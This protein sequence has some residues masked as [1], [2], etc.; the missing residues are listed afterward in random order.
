MVLALLTVIRAVQQLFL[1]VIYAILLFRYSVSKKFFLHFNF[2][3]FH[4]FF[5]LHLASHNNQTKS[6]VAFKI[7]QICCNEGTI[8]KRELKDQKM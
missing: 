4:F 8:K 6:A 5:A 3:V 7:S 1:W 2:H